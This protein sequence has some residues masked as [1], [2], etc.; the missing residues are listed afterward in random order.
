MQAYRSSYE[1]LYVCTWCESF[2]KTLKREEIDAR[3]FHTLEE[4][5]EHLDEFLELVYNRDRLHSAL[6]YQSPVDFEKQHA[7]RYPGM[8]WQ[9]AGLSFRRHQE[10]Y[11]DDRQNH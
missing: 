5:Q 2:L 7:H 11:P 10:I 6:D 8:Q 4:L 1:F 3:P 9:P